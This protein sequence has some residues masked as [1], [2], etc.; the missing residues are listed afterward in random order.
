M[1]D[2]D[3]KLLYKAL[4][5][6]GEYLNRWETEPYRLVIC[7]GA[8]LIACSLVD[9]TTQDVDIVA[10]LGEGC[11]LIS[12]DPLPEELLAAAKIVKNTL[13]LKD[14]W[15]NNGPSREP[16]GIFQLGFP[17][18][19]AARLTRMDFG[20]KLT[21]YFLDRY[22]QIHLKLYASVDSGPGGH[23]EDLLKLNPKEEE[24][25]AAANWAITHD[26]S[27]GFRMMLISML[28]KLGFRNVAEKI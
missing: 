8:A 11:K 24:L 10:L 22:D 14:N 18:G 3:D 27:P 13:E 2:L 16:G 5:F 23:V 26:P 15:L 4:S 25:E 7:G 20:P 9:R 28:E 19:L 12:P 17:E 6:L 21:A 1:Q